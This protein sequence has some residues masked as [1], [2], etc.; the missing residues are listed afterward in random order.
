MTE[1]PW[2]AELALAGTILPGTQVVANDRIDWPF[3]SYARNATVFHHDPQILLEP[4]D[5]GVILREFS[6]PIIAL[7]LTHLAVGHSLEEAS[8]LGHDVWPGAG[9]LAWDGCRLSSVGVPIPMSMSSRYA[10]LCVRLGDLELIDAFRVVGLEAQVGVLETGDCFFRI[11]PLLCL[12]G[13][14]RST[15]RPVALSGRIVSRRTGTLRLAVPSGFSR[16]VCRD[17]RVEP[18]VLHSPEVQSVPLGDGVIQI[19]NRNSTGAAVSIDLSLMRGWLQWVERIIP[20][21]AGD[22]LPEAEDELEC[23]DDPFHLDD[24]P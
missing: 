17:A 10:E 1:R 24:Q 22:A 14:C 6:R 16:L 11:D 8:Q 5:H 9:F 18:V 15:A 7:P 3:L 4:T 23:F 13:L 21:R 12:R 19:E 2:I 20:G